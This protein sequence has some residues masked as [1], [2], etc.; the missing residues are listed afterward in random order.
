MNYK[1]FNAFQYAKH[2]L[3]TNG[4]L[5]LSDFH[6]R[7]P[8]DTMVLNKEIQDEMEKFSGIEVCLAVRNDVAYIVKKGLWL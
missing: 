5:K 1:M 8:K 2:E 4:F 7:L 6:S 3:I